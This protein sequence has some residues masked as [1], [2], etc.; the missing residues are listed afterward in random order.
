ML[1]R[2][3]LCVGLCIAVLAK[4][5][6]AL[7]WLHAPRTAANFCLSVQHAC[8]EIEF[9]KQAYS[10]KNVRMAHGCATLEPDGTAHG[11]RFHKGLSAKDMDRLQTYVTVLR[12]P[13]ERILSNYCEGAT[14]HHGLSPEL[15]KELRDHMVERADWIDDEAV[16]NSLSFY[17]A[18]PYSRGCYVRMLT[19][20]M[21]SDAD[22]VVDEALTKQAIANLDQFLF[23]GV[24]ENYT[25]TVEVFLK[26][27]A[28]A[29]HIVDPTTFQV[30]Q[31]VG[32]AG[33]AG[34]SS[35]L[36]HRL[37]LQP[38]HHLE[39]RMKGEQSHNAQCEGAVGLLAP[40]VEDAF[41]QQ[42]YDHAKKVFVARYGGVLA[43]G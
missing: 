32:S 30:N 14:G 18:Q 38:A 24:S 42:V 9:L 8:N 17:L 2:L 5:P 12:P 41:D 34:M 40:K 6:C 10:A 29:G 33:G 11:N 35:S 7:N 31:P 15:Q 1:L 21:C 28:S 37:K 19:G 43:A 27:V 22:V 26:T 23:V 13:R 4:P 36:S 39:L 3:S 25:S 16:R 20:S